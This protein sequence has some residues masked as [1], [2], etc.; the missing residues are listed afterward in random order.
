LLAWRRRISTSAGFLNATCWSWNETDR[1]AARCSGQLDGDSRVVQGGTAC[2]GSKPTIVKSSNCSAKERH[3]TSIEKPY[4]YRSSRMKSSPK[5]K[6]RVVHGAAIGSLTAT[7]INLPSSKT[8]WRPVEP[9][10]CR[11]HSFTPAKR[12]KDKSILPVMMRA[13]IFLISPPLI[14]PN[15]SVVS[16]TH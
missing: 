16:P 7:R 10:N 14:A 1:G 12:S 8:S 2:R 5:K 13:S 3:W 9:S 4:A 6:S 11:N 15:S